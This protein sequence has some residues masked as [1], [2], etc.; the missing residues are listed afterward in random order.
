LVTEVLSISLDLLGI[1]EMRFSFLLVLELKFINY[2]NG[3]LAA[4][5]LISIVLPESINVIMNSKRITTFSN[6]LKSKLS[7]LRKT[8]LFFF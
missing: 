1:P 6:F 4:P 5:Q 2:F 8:L 3:I 7:I